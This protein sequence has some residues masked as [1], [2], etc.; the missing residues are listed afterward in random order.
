MFGRPVVDI[1]V[2]GFGI[3]RRPALR[4]VIADVEKLPRSDSAHGVAPIVGPAKV[5]SLFAHEHDVARGIDDAGFAALEHVKEAAAGHGSGG[6]EAG[7]LHECGSDI[8]RVDEV[9]DG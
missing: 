6:L 4:L 1:G 8:A 5:M 3:S 2:A 7:K 9:L